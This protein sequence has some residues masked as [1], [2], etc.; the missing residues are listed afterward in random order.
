MFQ[1]TLCL[2]RISCEHMGKADVERHISTPMHVSNAK[3]TKSQSTLTF[4]SVSTP[5]DEKV[6]LYIYTC[7]YIT[8][9]IFLL[10]HCKN[11]TAFRP[12]LDPAGALSSILSIKLAAKEPAHC[13]EPSSEVLKNAKA[14][15]WEFN[16]AHSRK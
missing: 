11:K 14:A 16:K 6:N 3:A 8:A 1:C 7:I 12:N 2:R 9:Y 4:H 5:I 13:F 15:T 10:Q